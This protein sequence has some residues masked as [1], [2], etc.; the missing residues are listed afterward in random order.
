MV[1]K[2]VPVRL[3]PSTLG[4]EK[5]KLVPAKVPVM[6]ASILLSAS[7]KIIAS[8]EALEVPVK[9]NVPAT[10][11][12]GVVAPASSKD[13]V[14]PAA[15]VK[16]PPEATVKVFFTLTLTVV[17]V[18][19][20]PPFAIV[21]LLKLLSFLVAI[22]FCGV[23]PLNTIVPF[24]GVNVP[25]TSFHDPATLCRSLLPGTNVPAAIEKLPSKSNTVFETA[26]VKLPFVIVRL[27]STS[28]VPAPTL[29]PLPPNSKLL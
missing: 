23:F 4:N 15:T 3:R 9:V 24:V 26:K 5:V 13:S 7:P 20:S 12:S 28:K 1:G 27:P 10:A 21:K 22:V 17:E 6:S 8:L 2:F 11:N 19:T 18:V 16:L 25:P 29:L 14:C